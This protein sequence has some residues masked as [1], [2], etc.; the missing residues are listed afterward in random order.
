MSK[1]KKVWSGLFFLTT[2]L[3]P[4]QYLCRDMRG[5]KLCIQKPGSRLSGEAG[6]LESRTVCRTGSPWPTAALSCPVLSQVWTHSPVPVEE[7]CALFKAVVQQ[8]VNPPQ[9]KFRII[10]LFREILSSLRHGSQNTPKTHHRGQQGEM[11][12][13][14]RWSDDHTHPT[15]PDF[16]DT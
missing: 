12:Y 3:K 2:V 13:S 11:I 6:V 4:V 16:Y 1:K 5:F 10:D 9:W 8:H 15:H 7:L 14:L